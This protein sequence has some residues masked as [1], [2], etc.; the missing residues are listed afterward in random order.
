[1]ARSGGDATMHSGGGEGFVSLMYK[2]N[3]E[4]T[5]VKDRVLHLARTPLPLV[6]EVPAI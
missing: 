4:D 2:A 6:A 1:M 3:S 5:G